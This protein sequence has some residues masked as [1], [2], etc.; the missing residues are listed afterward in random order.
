MRR[1]WL[2][3]AALP[4]LPAVASAQ[5]STTIL[6]LSSPDGDDAI[7]E[8]LTA[9]LRAAAEASRNIRYTAREVTLS[10]MMLAFGCDEPPDVDCM[11]QVGQQMQTDGVVYGYVRRARPNGDRLEVT[12]Y[13]F[14]VRGG[15]EASRTTDTIPPALEDVDALR[16]P[17]RRMFARLLGEPTTGTLR[18]AANVSGALVRVDGRDAGA[19]PL[20]LEVEMGAHQIEVGL[21]GHRPHLETV[22]VAPGQP[23]EV[24]AA[25]EPL[26]GGIAGSPSETPEPTDGGGERSKVNWP[27][28]VLF[29]G[30]AVLAGVG[31][32]FTMATVSANGDSGE[33]HDLRARYPGSADVCAEP[34][35]TPEDQDLC[36]SASLQSTLQFVF[37]G[38]GAIAGGI[39]LYLLLGDSG[40]AQASASASAWRLDPAIL[41]GGGG[42]VLTGALP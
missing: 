11:R 22:E 23:T 32:Y 34:T 39:G 25:L 42:L 3:L 24:R 30:G 2:V 1:A 7:A 4:A 31:L 35:L 27:G 40:E 41:R 15:R 14:D 28:W 8:N 26:S 18:I 10:Q 16:T 37:Y 6:G 20:S 13:V 36:D 33:F 29:G 38:A 21:E 9:M 19:A 12:L 5:P 17:A